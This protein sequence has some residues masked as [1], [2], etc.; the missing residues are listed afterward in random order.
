M[1][2]SRFWA[3]WSNLHVVDNQCIEPSGGVSRKIKP[4]LDTL[5]IVLSFVH[6]VQDKSCLWMKAW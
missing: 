1:L 3:L 6:T 4:V 5:T 2:L